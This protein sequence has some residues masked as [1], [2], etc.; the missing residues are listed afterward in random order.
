MRMPNSQQ[1]CQKTQ[2]KV[3]QW[4]PFES[5]SGCLCEVM[6]KAEKPAEM[7]M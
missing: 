5:N 4:L 2:V 7:G 3:D 1:G 6:L